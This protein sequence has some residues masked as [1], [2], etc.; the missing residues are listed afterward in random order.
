MRR[1]TCAQDGRA[2][3]VSLA[4]GDAMTG[5]A[6]VDAGSG[7]RGSTGV[8]GLGIHPGRVESGGGG[9]YAFALTNTPAVCVKIAVSSRPCTVQ[10]WPL[11]RHDTTRATTSSAVS[12]TRITWP[13]AMAWA[14]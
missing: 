11:A 6:A 10:A 3:G 12:T 4:V 13:G 1:R 9:P 7:P 2:H 5:I 14:Q 8:R